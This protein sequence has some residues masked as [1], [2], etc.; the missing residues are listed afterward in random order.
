[1]LWRRGRRLLGLLEAV[2]GVGGGRCTAAVERH[3]CCAAPLVVAV[4]DLFDYVLGESVTGR[5]EDLKG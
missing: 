2:C 1:M 4:L 3:A 5:E